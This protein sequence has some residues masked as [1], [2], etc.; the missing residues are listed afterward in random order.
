MNGCAKTKCVLCSE[1][2]VTTAA[3]MPVCEKHHNEYADEAER[4]LPYFMRDF[5]HRLVAAHEAHEAQTKQDETAAAE[6]ILDERK[7]K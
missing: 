5:W 3:Q 6:T 1:E 2:A 7:D 4:H